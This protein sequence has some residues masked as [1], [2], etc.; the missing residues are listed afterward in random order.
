MDWVGSTKWCEVIN[1]T[2]SVTCDLHETL[3]EPTLKDQSKEHCCLHD[4]KNKTVI[5]QRE[6]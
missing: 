6:A 1:L 3:W 2:P 4:S 5:N